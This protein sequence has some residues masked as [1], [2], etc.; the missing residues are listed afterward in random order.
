SSSRSSGCAPRR[1]ATTAWPSSS[2]CSRTST[3]WRFSTTWVRPRSRWSCDG[4]ARTTHGT[5]LS[6]GR[7]DRRSDPSWAHTRSGS[8][9]IRASGPTE[10]RRSDADAAELVRKVLQLER[11]HG[12]RDKAVVGGLESFV[13][14]WLPNGPVADLLDGYDGLPPTERALRIARAPDAA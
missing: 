13:R 2:S 12:F 8:P 14:R 4:S 11:S 5:G 3:R 10:P 1:A 7:M 9:S 6:L